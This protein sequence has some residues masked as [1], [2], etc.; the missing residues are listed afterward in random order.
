MMPVHFV[1]WQISG[2]M[3]TFQCLLGFFKFFI[4]LMFSFVSLMK[5][6]TLVLCSLSEDIKAH[7]SDTVLTLLR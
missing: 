4:I 7:R 6:I 1:H 3:L 2:I 5:S